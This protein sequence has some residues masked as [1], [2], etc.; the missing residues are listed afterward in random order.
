MSLIPIPFFGRRNGSWLLLWKG[1]RY[2]VCY[3]YTIALYGISYWKIAFFWNQVLIQPS[4]ISGIPVSLSPVASCCRVPMVYGA[5]Y[6]LNA[7]FTLVSL[8]EGA[9]LIGF[10]TRKWDR[11]LILLIFFIHAST[12]LFSDVFFAEFLVASFFFLKMRIWKNYILFL[13]GF[14][15]TH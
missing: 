4:T 10:F 12:Y 5:P 15:R 11:L 13:Q 6:L 8:L 7:G 2:Y 9:L 1:M 3:L 14:R